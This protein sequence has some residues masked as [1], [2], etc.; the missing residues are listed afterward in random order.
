M[1]RLEDHRAGGQ[2][3]EIRS[4]HD[5]ITGE[6]QRTGRELVR[7]ENQE[8]EW[9]SGVSGRGHADVNM[10]DDTAAGFR[11]RPANPKEM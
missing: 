1:S 7:Y 2:R 11:R 4:G 10:V 8:R 6:T 3:I 5:R 9:F